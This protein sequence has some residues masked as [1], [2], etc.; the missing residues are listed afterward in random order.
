[1]QYLIRTSA[2]AAG[3]VAFLH[4]PIAFAA[5][6]LT[7]DTM[8]SKQQ[9]L[10]MSEKALVGYQ[11]FSLVIQKEWTKFYNVGVVYKPISA[12]EF[13]CYIFN[14][15]GFSEEPDRL[16]LPHS[17]EA[18]IIN[19]IGTLIWDESKLPVEMSRYLRGTRVRRL[20]DGREGEVKAVFTNSVAYVKYDAI[21][22]L[23][24]HYAASVL[25]QLDLALAEH[26]RKE[27]D[28]VKKILGPTLL[29]LAGVAAYSLYPW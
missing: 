2:A 27:D 12:Q 29:A 22:K 21:D 8:L 18:R 3:L 24:V 11:M 16:S 26:P 14:D 20:G 13:S 23:P 25:D 19:E 7:F 17:S 10:A 4:A 28:V 6:S 5:A 9:D 15:Q 1:M